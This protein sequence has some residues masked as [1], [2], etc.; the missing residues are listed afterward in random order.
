[1]KKGKMI[2]ALLCCLLLFV[3]AACDNEEQSQAHVCTTYGTWTVLESASCTKEG[4]RVHSCAECYQS[5][6]EIIPKAEHMYT[7]DNYCENCRTMN[8]GSYTEGLVIEGGTLKSAGSAI[9]ASEIIIPA[10]HEG[11]SITYIAAGAFLGCE[12]TKRIVIPSTVTYVFDGAFSGCSSLEELTVPSIGYNSR[13]SG[14]KITVGTEPIACWFGENPYPGAVLIE[15]FV[16]LAYTDGGI[17]KDCYV[18]TSLKKITVVES[19]DHNL[20]GPVIGAIPIE[21]LV[22]DGSVTRLSVKTN[23]TLKN[24]IFA[25]NSSLTSLPGRTFF[26][27]KML[28]KIVLPSSIKSIDSA[29]FYG[30]V[31]LKEVVLPEGL[32]TIY[33][34]AFSNCENLAEISLPASLT[35]IGSDAFKGCTNLK[36]VYNNSRLYIEKGSESY[37]GVALYATQVI[38]E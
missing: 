30:C 8:P 15:Q 7:K 18:P 9:N 31:N 4:K 1:M 10:Y 35:S 22:I 25:E 36:T 24:V 32:E 38:K 2:L 21:T 12:N 17:T 19:A 11:K 26:D 6:E 5:Y 13:I 16:A 29:C 37:G 20:S 3:L 27:C 23:K 33:G 14:N 28:E 34:S